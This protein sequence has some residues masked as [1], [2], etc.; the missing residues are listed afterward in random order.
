MRVE[1]FVACQKN[2]TRLKRSLHLLGSA[3]SEGRSP[4]CDLY[5]AR[6]LPQVFLAQ[7][8]EVIVCIGCLLTMARNMVLSVSGA[9]VR[10]GRISQS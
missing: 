3:L 1:N 2:K 5:N 6:S 8:G 9:P 7:S 4:R 10:L